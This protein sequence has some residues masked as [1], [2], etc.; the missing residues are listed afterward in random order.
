MHL[1]QAVLMIGVILL[2][3]SLLRHGTY[4]A[5]QNHSLFSCI[6][7][8]SFS[9]VGILEHFVE[10]CHRRTCHSKFPRFFNI[11]FLSQFVTLSMKWAEKCARKVEKSSAQKTHIS[12]KAI[13]ASYSQ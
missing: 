11:M 5:R 10:P 6:F 9:F 13:N 1:Q 2:V 3:L 7:L 8:N 12:Y 4:I